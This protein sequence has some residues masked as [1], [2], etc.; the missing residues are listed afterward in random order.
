[1]KNSEQQTQLKQSKSSFKLIVKKELECKIRTLCSNISSVEWSGIL[2]YRY[3]GDLNDDTFEVECVDLYL[4]DI[5]SSTFTEFETSPEI[6]AYIADNLDLFDCQT[7]LI[8]SHNNMATFFSGTDNKTLL[9]QGQEN[10]HFLSLIVNNEGNYTAAITRQINSEYTIN[11]ICEYKSFGDKIIKQKNKSK[12]T[13][14]FIEKIPAK[15]V[16]EGRY[17]FSD[18]IKEIKESK[19]KVVTNFKGTLFDDEI[20]LD[21]N[22]Y[23]PIKDGWADNF[24]KN[25]KPNTSAKSPSKSKS[26]QLEKYKGHFEYD[27]VME[28]LDDEDIDKLEETFDEAGISNQEFKEIAIETLSFYDSKYNID[29]KVMNNI[30]DLL[31]E[32]RITSTL[33]SIIADE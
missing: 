8:H 6:A 23:K 7:G 16:V 26:E 10:N 11:E 27:I 29:Y 3:K 15:I 18:R 4:M 24:Y 1:M 17:D 14:K 20:T 5:G 25:W 9:E 28:I 31:P 32:N 12:G 13:R 21:T 19:T 22:Q 33:K 30:V 2:F